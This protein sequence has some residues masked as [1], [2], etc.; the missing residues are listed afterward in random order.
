M[1]PLQMCIFLAATALLTAGMPREEVL[2]KL[3]VDSTLVV[4]GNGAEEVVL[5]DTAAEVVRHKGHPGRV[6]GSRQVKDLFKDIYG[7]EVPVKI[8]FE[9]IL[10]YKSGQTAVF[11]GEGKAV[12]VAGYNRHRVTIDAVA[13][14]SGIEHFIFNYG[15]EGLLL[16]S[17]GEHRLYVYPK[18]GI[19]LADDGGDG[20]IDMYIVFTPQ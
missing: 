12:A 4:P 9:K 6:A 13:I 2:I 15:N 17:K 16:F 1:M 18:R 5:G 20:T 7:Q 19:A 11:I 14:D 3:R 8:L 10:Y